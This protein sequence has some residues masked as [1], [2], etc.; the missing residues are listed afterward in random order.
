[1]NELELKNCWVEKPTEEKLSNVSPK[2]KEEAVDGF[3]AIFT[4]KLYANGHNIDYLKDNPDLLKQMFQ[5]SWSGN[6]EKGLL[7]FKAIVQ[8]PLVFFANKYGSIEKA[9]EAK[10]GLNTNRLIIAQ[11][12]PFYGEVANRLNKF[13]LGAKL[14]LDDAER[15]DRLIDNEENKIERGDFIEAMSIDPRNDIQDNVKLLLA[16]LQN[17][18]YDQNGILIAKQ[19]FFKLPTLVDFDLVKRTIINTV[20]DH[21]E[22]EEMV[23]ELNSKFYNKNTGIYDKGYEW[24]VDLKKRLCLVDEKGKLIKSKNLTDED[25][26][27]RI[28]FTRSFSKMVAQPSRHIL[29]S[30]GDVISFNPIERSSTQDITTEWKNNLKYQALKGDNDLFLEDALGLHINRNSQLYHNFVNTSDITDKVDQENINKVLIKLNSLGID[31]KKNT[32]QIISKRTR[33]ADNHYYNNGRIILDTYKYIVKELRAT[34]AVGE[35]SVSP[36][37]KTFTDLFESSNLSDIRNLSLIN[38]SLNPEEQSMMMLTGKG[39]AQYPAS[40]P[41]AIGRVLTD[42]NQ[43]KTLAEFIHKRPYL[44]K[45]DYLDVNTDP[46]LNMLFDKDGNHYDNAKCEIGFSG[47][48]GVEESE[49]GEDSKGLTE[50][51]RV[52]QDFNNALQFTYLVAVNSDKSTDWTMSIHRPFVYMNDTQET[53]NRLFK[54]ALQ[55]EVRAAIQELVEPSRVIFYQDEVLKLGSFRDILPKAAVDLFV[56][57]ILGCTIE[58]GKVKR[59]N[60]LLSKQEYLDKTQ[61]FFNRDTLPTFFEKYQNEQA[62]NYLQYLI[63]KNIVKTKDNQSYSITGVSTEELRRLV[64]D[65]DLGRIPK[66]TMLDITKYLTTNFNF[67]RFSQNKLIFGNLSFYKDAWKRFSMWNGMKVQMNSD[68]DVIKEFQ[69]R[70]P[71]TDNRIDNIGQYEH[72]DNPDKFIKTIVHKDV[73]FIQDGYQDLAKEF[74][75][76]YSKSIADKSELEKYIGANF[77]ENGEFQKL[78]LIKGKP[79]GLV[80][81]YINSKGADSESKVLIDHWW[82]FRYRIGDLS[83]E[84]L[85]LM[86]YDRAYEIVDIGNNEELNKHFNY[87]KERIAEAEAILEKYNHQTPTVPNGKQKTQFAG[88]DKN[89]IPVGHKD[90]SA[91]ICRRNT[92]GKLIEQAYLEWK[93][94]GID[95]ISYESGNK[96]GTLTDANGELTNFIGLDG[97]WSGM[98][99][100]IQDLYPQGMGQQVEFPE[101]DKLAGTQMEKQMFA[102]SKDKETKT[103][104]HDTIKK[105]SKLR[106]ENFIKNCGIEFDSAENITLK[107]ARPLQKKI[108]TNLLKAGFPDNQV[109]AVQVE[110]FETGKFK[111]KLPFD[112]LSSK[113]A[114]ENAIWKNINS[115]VITPKKFGVPALISP[116]LGNETSKVRLG[117]LDKETGL[118]VEVTDP[119][120]LPD[121]LKKNLS[122]ITDKEDAQHIS[123]GVAHGI[124][125]IIPWMFLKMK[126]PETGELLTPKDLGLVQQKDGTWI[127]KNKVQDPRLLDFISFR[128]PTP[129]RNSISYGRGMSILDPSEGQTAYVN[130]SE[131]VRMGKDFDGDKD[132]MLFYNSRFVTKN[133]G[134]DQFKKHLNE[135]LTALNYDEESLT[136]L[137]NS[138]GYDE[139]NRINNAAWTPTGQERLDTEENIKDMAAGNAN[140]KT[141]LSDIKKGIQSYNT[142]FKNKNLV[143]EIIE[144]DSEKGLE[145]KILTA[146]IK[147]LQ[148]PEN[149]TD[150]MSPI[151][152]ITIED[153]ADEIR[154]KLNIKGLDSNRI[155]YN[156]LQ[157]S[158]EI[159]QLFLTAR[160]LVG[161]F[162]R[163]SAKHT[164]IESVGGEELSGTYLPTEVYYLTQPSRKFIKDLERVEIQNILGI[165]DRGFKLGKTFDIVGQYIG[166]NLTSILQAI[167]DY[168]K[169]PAL[170]YCGVNKITASTASY[171]TQQGVDFK[172]LSFFLSQPIIREFAALAINDGSILNKATGSQSWKSGIYKQLVCKYMGMNGWYTELQKKFLTREDRERINRKI[173]A[174]VQEILNNTTQEITSENL[175]KHLAFSLPSDDDNQLHSTKFKALKNERDFQIKVL[176]TYLQFS[177]QAQK[178]FNLTQAINVDTAKLKTFGE[179]QLQRY[180][181]KKVLEDGYVIDLDK[182]M[183]NTFLQAKV[184]ATDAILPAV[185]HYFISQNDKFYAG[186]SLMLDRLTSDSIFMTTDDKKKEINKFNNFR[187]NHIIQTIGESPLYAKAEKLLFGD[188]SY[189]KELAKYKDKYKDSIALKNIQ[190]LIS[191]IKKGG[192]SV[193]F[194]KMSMS[195]YDVNEIDNAIVDEYIRYQKKDPEYSQFLEKMAMFSLIQTGMQSSRNSIQKIIPHEL[196]FNST[197]QLLDWRGDNLDLDENLIDKQYFQNNYK[198]DL[199][200]TLTENEFK[201]DVYVDEKN[202][203]LIKISVDNDKSEL[204]YLKRV[205]SADN[206]ATERVRN[207]KAGLGMLNNITE[208]YQKVEGLNDG[209]FA[210]YKRI[211]ILGKYGEHVEV[212]RYDKDN[213]IYEF[214][215]R[216]ISDTH[217]QDIAKRIYELAYDRA[218]QELTEK[219]GIVTPTEPEISDIPKKDISSQE[220]NEVLKKLDQGCK[221]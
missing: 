96:F 146:Q 116:M 175:D 93:K 9:I 21:Y 7:G 172:S 84:D 216:G 125:A 186:T 92:K 23:K 37:V 157:R 202:N 6:P 79:Q 148:D 171:L 60:I 166:Q 98:I 69:K 39:E 218:Y 210:Y 115:D 65:L 72:S 41:S 162:A 160:S 200:G 87:S 215:N 150:L 139:F 75:K 134:S 110:E 73:L 136:N 95:K 117:Y 76:T 199:V 138:F 59:P 205:V 33:L 204:D 28:G 163:A 27:L 165:G 102:N 89:G 63:D 106:T 53:V 190:P 94:K 8:D 129:A 122:V 206:N 187:L 183:N 46:L 66:E 67:A 16:T 198:S 70:Y 195:S 124:K 57:D 120:T 51:D 55:D 114:I 26:R 212:S 121:N 58:N 128:I 184:D 161:I 50:T 38:N 34:Y 188:N 80:G 49:E 180:Q 18:Y 203:N 88:Y 179:K 14:E 4:D 118:V 185:E 221:E 52:L 45:R 108:R 71:R 64:P 145:N 82:E 182:T 62:T 151:S 68:H 90:S 207:K 36:K 154:E 107:D 178:D 2:R 177:S 42:L 170:G 12:G 11:E 155:S 197:K 112:V 214:N 152:M 196:W 213:S 192:D 91:Y 126:H 56:T 168:A 144:D 193:R 100:T 111:I 191:Q 169:N 19:S 209:Y 132:N 47:G 113:D 153:V 194:F 135:H 83:K 174:A 85:N 189:A 219:A 48:M 17:K 44:N 31:F 176:V 137:H 78:L 54:D 22:L 133:F 24:L 159:R 201:K 81:M 77:T 3:I 40:N 181:I 147:L 217:N 32:S 173:I 142:K 105:L 167:L 143:L 74:Y 99:P 13:G 35:A 97:K 20:K 30:K 211:P 158:Q 140:M 164:I 25:I 5:E 127:D 104:I 131:I 119:N 1:M 156:E 43:S 130:M 109:E 10:P 208:L 61:E 149:F 123:D 220:V 15:V 86:E 29:T 103:L 101:K 141:I